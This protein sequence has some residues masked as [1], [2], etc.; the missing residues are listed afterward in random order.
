MKSKA[1][2]LFLVLC[3]FACNPPIAKKYHT[4]GEFLI[5]VLT[6]DSA[7]VFQRNNFG[8]MI[9]TLKYS[10]EVLPSSVSLVEYYGTSTYTV[11]NIKCLML[12]YPK[13]GVINLFRYQYHLSAWEL[14]NADTVT[15]EEFQKIKHK[16][17]N[18][19]YWDTIDDDSYPLVGDKISYSSIDIGTDSIIMRFRNAPDQLFREQ[20]VTLTMP[21][22]SQ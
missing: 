5:P 8:E 22:E 11:S 14:F 1:N 15:I 9:D 18:S 19:W 16:I 17:E 4:V 13:E 6:E 7:Q 3:V 20:I 12:K 21:R 2:F 10:G